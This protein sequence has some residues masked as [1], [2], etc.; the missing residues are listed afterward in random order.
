MRGDR[1]MRGTRTIFDPVDVTTVNAGGQAK[2]LQFTDV[3]GDE[4]LVQI[5]KDGGSSFG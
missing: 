2:V 1:D 3:P 5:A 4:T